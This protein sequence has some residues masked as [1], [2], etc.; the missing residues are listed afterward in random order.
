MTNLLIFTLVCF[1]WLPNPADTNQDLAGYRL[2]CGPQSGIYTNVIEIKPER[3]RACASVARGTTN[4]FTLTAVNA[5]GLESDPTPE[6]V[7]WSPPPAVVLTLQ[8]S[9]DLASWTNIA[10]ITNLLLLGAGAAGFYR[11]VVEFR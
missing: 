8:S 11:G 6:L 9:G 2:Y 1:K 10:S 3:T 5:Q 7:F 4:Y